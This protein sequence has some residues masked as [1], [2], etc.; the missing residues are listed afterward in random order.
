VGER[1]GANFHDE[2]FSWL[3]EEVQG[4]WIKNNGQGTIG[5]EQSSDMGGNRAEV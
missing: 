2:I 4:I 5:K 1:K 3:E